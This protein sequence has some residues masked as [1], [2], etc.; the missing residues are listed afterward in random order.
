MV[1][2]DGPIDLIVPRL[3]PRRVPH[4]VCHRVPG[5]P[6]HE[7]H[8]VHLPHPAHYG[9]VPREP[10]RPFADADPPCLGN[11]RDGDGDHVRGPRDGGRA[12]RTNVRGGH[13]PP[14]FLPCHGERVHFPVP[15]AVRCF[16]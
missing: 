12:Y 3:P 14:P 7:F 5:G 4:R 9:G 11:V 13:G 15:V 16:P 8:A 2:S 1:R 10:Q 6:V